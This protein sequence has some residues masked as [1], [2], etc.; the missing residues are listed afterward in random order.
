MSHFLSTTILMWEKGRFG[1]ISSA[2]TRIQMQFKFS[3]STLA[4]DKASFLEESLLK[5]HVTLATNKQ[6]SRFKFGIGA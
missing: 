1:K 2:F 4:A 6:T 5:L 3:W